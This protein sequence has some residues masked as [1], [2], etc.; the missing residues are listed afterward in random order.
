MDLR[1]VGLSSRASFFLPWLSMWWELLEQD[2]VKLPLP[3]CGCHAYRSTAPDGHLISWQV[4][5]W[6][7][8]HW[9]MKAPL[10][11]AVICFH[12]GT[13]VRI[14]SYFECS[15]LEKR[16][17]KS[18][19]VSGMPPL[20]ICF[21]FLNPHRDVKR[22]TRL[23]LELS[24]RDTESWNGL[25]NKW[26]SQLSC[27][28][29]HRGQGHLILNQVAPKPIQPGLE[30]FQGWSVHK[31]SGKCV[32]VTHQKWAAGSHSAVSPWPH[33]IWSLLF[34][35]AA[36]KVLSATLK[37]CGTKSVGAQMCPFHFSSFWL[38]S[39]SLPSHL[40]VTFEKFLSLKL[41]AFPW[42]GTVLHQGLLFSAGDLQ[43]GNKLPE[44]MEGGW[45]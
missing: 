27:S 29:P 34:L 15:P 6:S 4:Y 19:G 39:S 12:G 5:S 20:H 26:P 38:F 28:N 31:F 24:T 42:E 3:A 7:W 10:P 1:P 25:G 23:G 32:P 40:R 21:A 45:C 35:L 43:N 41:A 22:S 8:R 2:S 18:G 33:N 36:T 37:D 44:E 14:L 13:R 11:A 30:R 9:K 17:G 16:L